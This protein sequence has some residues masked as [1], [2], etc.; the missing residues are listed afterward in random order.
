MGKKNEDANLEKDFI[1]I[2]GSFVDRIITVFEKGVNKMGE[3]D[4]ST[5]I[6]NEI[7]AGQKEFIESQLNRMQEKM[8]KTD[9]ESGEYID[10]IQAYDKLMDLIR[11]W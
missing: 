10:L 5:T 3:K 6:K 11:W 4:I 7:T 8:K 9:I 1:M 2:P